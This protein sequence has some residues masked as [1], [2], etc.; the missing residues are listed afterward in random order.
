MNELER[1]LAGA[2]AAHRALESAIAPLT[3]QRVRVPSLLPDWTV[4]HVLTHIARNADGVRAMLEGALR[5]EVAPQYP[6]GLDQRTAD[7]EAGAQRD[8]AAI[9]ADVSLSNE[10][11][12]AV[13]LAMTPAAWAGHG[14]TVMGEAPCTDLPFRR[15]RETVVHLADAGLGYTWHDWP[16]D[17]RRAELRRMT[18]LWNSRQPMGLTGLPAAAV[19]APE[20]LR[21]AWLLGRADIDGLA[22][23]GLTA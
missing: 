7:I 3:D 2:T 10:R 11:L 13:W 16:A 6:G 14:L 1:D 22:P 20:P 21:V 18:M 12:E 9:V 8:A 5:D 19:A 4:G 17:Y 15:W 23:A